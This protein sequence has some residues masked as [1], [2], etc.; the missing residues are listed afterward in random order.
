MAEL[1]TIDALTE[2]FERLKQ[3]K[4][5][6]SGGIESRVLTNLAFLYGEQYVSY[7]NKQLTVEARDENKLYLV[8]NLIEPRCSKLAGRLCSIDPPFKARPDR[9]EP[10]AFAKAEV[11]DRLTIALDQKLDEPSRMWERIFWLQVGGTCFEYSP[12][13]P[14]SSIEPMPQFAD[15][16]ELLFKHTMSDNIVPESVMTTM[17]EQGMP[18]E[19]FEIYETIEPVGEVGSEILGPLNV[20]IDQGVRSIADLSPD[21]MVYIAK[22]RTMGWIEENFDTTVEPDKDFQIVSTRFQ[23]NPG[24]STNGTSLSDLIP[25]VQG[26]RGDDDPEMALVVE[27][28][29][30]RS[31][32]SP[33]GRYVAFVPKKKILYD[34]ENPYGDIPLVDF[35]WK[36]VTTSFW[37]PDY[38]TNLVAPQRFLNKR[39]S[40]LGENTNATIYSQ[41]LLGGTLKAADVATDTNGIVEKGM[42]ENGAPLVARLVAPPL[43]SYFMNS[44]EMVMKL[45]ND[46]AGGSDLFGEGS[47][48]GQLRGPMAVPML[49]EILDTEWGPFYNHLGERLS[50]V[51][52]MRLNRVKQFYPASR[53][54]HYT[55][56]NQKDEVLLFHTEEILRSGV[57]FDVTCERG[58]LMPELRALRESRVSNRL[59]GPLAILYMDEQTGRLDKSKIAQ[60]LQFGE[61]GREARENQY[62]KLAGE[63][64]DMI[65][66]GEQVPPVLPFYDHKAMM[67]EIEATMATTEFLKATPQVQQMFFQRW[68][69]HRQFLMQQAQAQQAMIQSHFVQSAVAQATQQAA[70]QAASY[71]VE[72]SLDQIKAQVM[73]NQQNPVTQQTAQTINNASP[74]QQR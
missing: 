53:T 67:D 51:K 74:G 7:A 63:I 20:F 16:Q 65:W 58:S 55:D 52:Q 47:F 24:M 23:Q 31:K 48:P 64:N 9:K 11:V 6:A 71:T 72:S 14:N 25:V 42:A 34:G 68:E 46:I 27:G 19:Q 62:R 18:Q 8:F 40:Q 28:Y 21:Q 66:R 2:D 12:W 22:I 70:A 54:M 39:L 4:V 32:R 38:V 61:T 50:K 56:R 44:I 3:Q 69:G 1:D 35:H 10:K 15:N 59:A 49:Q 60:D 43:P 36:P 73:A 26:T 29:A 57:N 5:K 45:F 17:I 41:L 13:I 33:R 37:T 30:P